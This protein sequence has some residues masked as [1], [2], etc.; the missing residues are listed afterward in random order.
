[1]TDELRQ[2]E[3]EALAAIAAAESTAGLDEADIAYLGRRNG[4]LTGMMRQLGS[5]P[6]DQKPLF[7]QALNEAKTRVEAALAERKATLA[8]AELAVRE[9]AEAIDVTLPG[10]GRTPGRLHPLTRTFADVKQVFFGAGL[11]LCGW[12]RCGGLPL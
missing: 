7:G 11:H 5:L 10:R 8:A 12:P 9:Q 4:K 2:V 1:M 3:V 6:A